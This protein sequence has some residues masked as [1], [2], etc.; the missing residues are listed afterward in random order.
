MSVRRTSSTTVAGRNGS[1]LIDANWVPI[2]IVQVDL[3]AM[4]DV[5]ISDVTSGQRVWM[6]VVKQGQ[7]VGILEVVAE[8]GKLTL[9]RLEELT[10]DFKN[11]VVSPHVAVP[12]D[13]LPPATVVVPTIC[14]DPSRLLLTVE[15]LLALDYPDFDIIVVDN[16]RDSRSVPLPS[17]PGG[18]RVRVFAEPKP[19]VSAARNR[20][21]ANAT[22]EFIAFTDDDVVIEV[23]WLRELGTRF[24][25][26]PEVDGIGGLVLPTELRTQPQLWFEEFFGGFNHTFSA[27]LLSMELLAKTDEMF[28]YATG[29]FGAGCNMAFRRSALQRNGGFDVTLGTGTPAR[30]GEDLAL[31]MKQV[32]TGGTLAYEPRAVVHHQHRQSDDAFLTQVFGYGVGLT[33]MFTALIIRDPRHL[34]KMIRRIPAGYRLLTKPRD[35]RSPSTSAS[36][37]RRAYVRHLLGMVYGPV[38][39][40]RSVLRNYFQ[41]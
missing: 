7:V 32:L 25:T 22:G 11:M 31:F 18:D 36:Y 37:P 4:T 15:T 16:R 17:F 6:E 23:N 10:V 13:L 27:E 21:I 35:E 3:D 8:G 5:D 30:G 9:Q 2:P 38:A 19:G 28:P 40:A 20:G 29:R 26:S 12:D 1:S 34:A 14:Q 41:D 24:V 39:Y 33:A